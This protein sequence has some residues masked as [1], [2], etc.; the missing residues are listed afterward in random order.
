LVHGLIPH[1][2]EGEEARIAIPEKDLEKHAEKKCNKLGKKCHKTEIIKLIGVIPG[3]KLGKKCK[4]PLCHFKKHKEEEGEEEHEGEHDKP[5]GEDKPESV[6][7]G[8]KAVKQKSVVKGI[9]IVKPNNVVWGTIAAKPAAPAKKP[10]P[11]APAV[12]ARKSPA[13]PAKQVAQPLMKMPIT[14]FAEDE[15]DE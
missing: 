1:H 7:W 14:Q 13:L 8:T 11:V 12:P 15:D 6:V 4:L 5:E 3:C 2:K 9:K 10:T